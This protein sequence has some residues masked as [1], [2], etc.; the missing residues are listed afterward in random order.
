MLLRGVIRHDARLLLSESISKDAG[1]PIRYIDYDT[2]GPRTK[3]ALKVGIVPKP[4]KSRKKKRITLSDYL[5][6]IGRS[7]MTVGVNKHG[8][9]KRRSQKR[10]RDIKKNKR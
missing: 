4:K 8:R 7:V 6:V 3:N 5:S 9:N 2:G 10:N 1:Y